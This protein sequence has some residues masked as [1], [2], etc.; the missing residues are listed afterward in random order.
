MPQREPG[1]IGQH[2]DVCTLQSVGKSQPPGPS[3]GSDSDIRIPSQ[4]GE[5]VP[6]AF[7]SAG[8][9]SNETV[10]FVRGYGHGLT[11]AE[12]AEAI[13]MTWQKYSTTLQIG[14][15]EMI[16]SAIG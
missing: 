2:R 4:G 15:A 16:L 3:S 5:L 7:E 9:P 13:G 12:R 11:G 6:L 10:A 8:R 1:P 14:N